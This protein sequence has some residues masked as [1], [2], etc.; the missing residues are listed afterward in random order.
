MSVFVAFGLKSRGG[1]HT[2][3]FH[4]QTS[5][6]LNEARSF[7]HIGVWTKDVGLLW[8]VLIQSHS[9]GRWRRL[10]ERLSVLSGPFGVIN[11]PLDVGRTGRK[12]QRGRVICVRHRLR[13]QQTIMFLSP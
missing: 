11:R 10:A 4:Q 12:T 2:P 6:S 7:R 8:F 3:S 13:T 5:F 9:S 1:S